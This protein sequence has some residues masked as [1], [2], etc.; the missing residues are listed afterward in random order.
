MKN[1]ANPMFR[2]LRQLWN[3]FLNKSRT[4]NHEPLNKVSLVVII[5]IDI[6][7]LFQVFSG[8]S[9]ISRWHLSPGEAY[10]CYAEWRDYRT[11]TAKDKDYDMV[12]KVLLSS[13]YQL[14]SSVNPFGEA[15]QRPQEGRLGKVSEICANYTVLKNKV[16]TKENQ[17]SLKTIDQKQSKIGQLEQKN[18]Q[19]RSQYDSTLL[20]KI[21]GQPGDRSIN[22][23]AADQAK[24]TLERNNQDIA[25]LKKE[26][27]NFKND[28]LAKAQKIGYFNSLKSDNLFVQVEKGYK[29]ASF[30]H[31]SIQLAL[32]A[33]FLVPLLLFAAGIHSF[34]LRKGYGLIALI[35]WH[36]LVIFCVPLIIKVF[37]FLQIGVIFQF[38][39]DIVSKLLGGLL[40][41]VSYVYILLIPL[42]GF[43]L[44]KFF[45]KFVFNTRI[46]ASNRIQKSCCARCAKKIRLQDSYCPHCGYYQYIE[47]PN[48]HNLTYKHLS[49]CRDCGQSQT[50]GS[51]EL[52][53]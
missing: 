35:S 43:G 53:R 10:P 24:Q 23:V 15:P 37:E 16:K 31:P 25:V 46:Q 11:Q 12:R 40:F 5:L 30:W 17:Q 21:A 19:I 1:S 13:E 22:T 28:L 33:C 47:C 29:Q 52:S 50:M 34:A 39:F 7:I 41:L 26:I 18:R 20:E 51:E 45:Q 4:I 2:F 38:I 3:R 6:F 32:Q 42:V 44:I 49:Y 9:E 14:N 8:L 36:L 48:C 27:L